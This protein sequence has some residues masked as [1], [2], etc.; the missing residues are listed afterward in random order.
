MGGEDFSYMLEARPGVKQ[1]AVFAS[2]MSALVNAGYR[3]SGYHKD[4]QAVKTDAP[5]A[6][7]WD[8]L[9]AWARQHPR[10]KSPPEGSLEAQ[11]MAVEPRTAVDFT[12]APSV[13]EK[14]RQRHGGESMHLQGP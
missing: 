5:P 14:H 13:L 8:V 1:K 6:V 4:P 11:I 9:R 7:V 12:P 3:V 10:A 2:K